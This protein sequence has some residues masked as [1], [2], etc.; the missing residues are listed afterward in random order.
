MTLAAAALPSTAM[1][2]LGATPPTFV[3]P[4]ILLITD[5]HFTLDNYAE[6]APTY[7]H[8]EHYNIECCLFNLWPGPPTADNATQLTAMTNTYSLYDSVTVAVAT[9][10]TLGLNYGTTGFRLAWCRQTDYAPYYDTNGK[11]FG[12]L[13]FTV[14]CQARVPSLS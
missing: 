4:V 2:W 13:E 14:E 7:K 11:A 8:E 1:V 10:P 5:V 9:N 3:A 12:K 6:M